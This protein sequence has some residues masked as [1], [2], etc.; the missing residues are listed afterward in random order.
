MA[1]SLTLH[2]VCHMTNMMFIAA[3]DNNGRNKVFPNLS[4]MSDN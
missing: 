1:A 4:V 2:E 3:Y